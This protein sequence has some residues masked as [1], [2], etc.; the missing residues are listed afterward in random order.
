MKKHTFA[1]VLCLLSCCF[2]KIPTTDIFNLS[3]ITDS[4]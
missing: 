1:I 4:R 2:I 3:H